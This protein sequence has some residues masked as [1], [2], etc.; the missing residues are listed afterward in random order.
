MQKN[1]DESFKQYYH[2]EKR[3][4]KMN[5]NAKGHGDFFIFKKVLW[6]LIESEEKER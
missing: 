3:P 2:V 6:D 4:Q 5:K 1:I